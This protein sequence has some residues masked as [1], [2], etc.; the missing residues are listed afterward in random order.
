MSALKIR[1]ICNHFTTTWRDVSVGLPNIALKTDGFVACYAGL[2][3]LV[4]FHNELRLIITSCELPRA[5]LVGVHF[6][7]HHESL[8]S[9]SIFIV[10]LFGIVQHDRCKCRNGPSDC[11]DNNAED[12]EATFVLRIIDV[13][14]IR[15][16][17]ESIRTAADC[18]PMLGFR[19]VLQAMRATMPAVKLRHPEAIVASVSAS[20]K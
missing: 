6:S 18:E 8:R 15:E 14:Q 12:P 16:G 1:M 5:V 13:S 2:A 7:G 19:S 9:A 17:R 3:E 10:A 4:L 20:V 11:R